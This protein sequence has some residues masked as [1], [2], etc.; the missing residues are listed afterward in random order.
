MATP[1]KSIFLKLP[2]EATIMARTILTK[3]KRVKVFFAMIF[4]VEW[5]FMG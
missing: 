3:L 4:Q 2:T 5:W 1:M